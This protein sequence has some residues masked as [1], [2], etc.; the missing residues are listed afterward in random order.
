MKHQMNYTIPE[1]K[2]RVS[3][4]FGV[5]LD[6]VFGCDVP[7]VVEYEYDTD[8][9][10]PA[11]VRQMVVRAAQDWTLGSDDFELVIKKGANL[12]NA[13]QVADESAIEEAIHKHMKA[14]ADD[15]SEASLI[16][17]NT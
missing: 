3:N 5:A 7:V 8:P 6:S 10:E 12:N 2:A 17:A 14:I 11:Q 9:D 16:L 1:M 4:V 15:E 13:I